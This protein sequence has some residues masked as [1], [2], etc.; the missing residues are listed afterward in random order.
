MGGAVVGAR[1]A[2]ALVAACLVAA[3][4]SVANAVTLPPSFQEEVV[5]QGLT[6]P[7]TVK[8]A[9]D[10]RVFVAEQSGRILVFSGLHDPT[11]T[12]FADLRTNVHAFWD[13][14]LLGLALDP[15]FPD[16]PYVYVLYTHDAAIGG[17]APRWGSVGGSS[18]PC[19]NPPGALA[20]GCVVS[21][22]L[23]RLVAAGDQMTGSE[24]V[25][26]EDWCQQ[27]PSH[28]VGD[29]EFG[30]DGALYASAGDGAAFH[31]LDYGQTGNP[32]GDGD[33]GPQSIPE[34]EGGSLRSQDL[35]TRDDPVGLSGTVVR[36][37]PATG[38]ALLDNPLAMDSDVNARRIVAYGLRNPF[39]MAIRPGTDE[40]WV[41]DVGWGA[42]EEINRLFTPTVGPV[43]NFGW[44]CYEG[45]PRQ[46]TWDSTGVTICESLYGEGTASPPHYAYDH[47]SEPDDPCS[48]QSSS[49]TGIAFFEGSRY[50]GYDG[51]LFFADYS[52]NCIWAMPV[53]HAGVPDPTDIET[54]AAGASSPTDLT[55][56]PGGDLY[57]VDYWGG[58]VRRIVYLGA[59]DAP[60]A[61]VEASPD[62][63]PTPLTVQFDASG[64]SDP[65][66]DALSYAWDLDGDGGHDDST[67]ER[68]VQTYERRGTYV[69]GVKVTDEQGASSVASATI[70]PA[71]SR[72]AASID[73]P[74]TATAWRVG[75]RI[76][77]AGSASDSDDGVLP[78][79]ALHWS[80]VLQ[81][82]PSTC[83]GHAIQSWAGAAGGS[84]DAP[85][86]EYPSHLELTL[87]ATDS[88]GATDTETIRLDPITVPL[89]FA[90]NP[91]GLKLAVGS[92][93]GPAPFERV[94]IAG[95]TNSISAPTPQ[96]DWSFSSWSDRGA[97]SHEITAP[98]G[99]ETYTATY[100]RPLQPPPPPPPPLPPP[101]APPPG[102]A[103]K[104]VQCVVPRLAGRQLSA[105]RI[106]LARA[107][108]RLGKVSRAYS[109][110]GAGRVLSQNPRS[111]TR[112][113]DRARVAL[114]VSRGPKKK[115]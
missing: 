43:E 44:P 108:C 69:V 90:T 71:N 34:T 6:N 16:S 96:G 2:G 10:G 106:L 105:T 66:G 4:S 51:A 81:H 113:P 89:T 93:S 32:C 60:T 11:P 52:R 68:P 115:R 25:L 80:L 30:P 104:A 14:G 26:I 70:L 107:R 41:G 59:N 33:G 109:R 54:F 50:P 76:H 22:R 55:M 28:T 84:L 88:D 64:S 24:H 3:A 82:C 94:V 58:A 1:M 45:L 42:A 74:S 83:H 38:N 19:P 79:A 85:D 15:H 77:F 87:T 35:R 111:S 78:D 99:A 23:S 27:Y 92:T 102:P 56:G 86:H 17:T 39:R 5:L 97:R 57:Y 48:G 100:E 37:D 101:P 46:S 65:N 103:P 9:P 98:D 7:T 95:S 49:T 21:A 73:S 31:R 13:R 40:L 75:D 53:N 114:R 110:L 112:L 91:P 72:P 47:S 8:F 20:D 61:L 36:V 62:E 18:D 67:E 12:V 29:L 63:G